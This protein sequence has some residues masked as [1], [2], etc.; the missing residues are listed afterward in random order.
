MGVKTVIGREKIAKAH[1]GEITLPKIKF[2]AIGEGGINLVNGQPKNLSGAETSLFREVLRKEAVLTRVNSTQLNFKVT[3][4][5]ADNL[6][7]K[8]ISEAALFDEAGDMIAIKTFTEKPLDAQ[9][10]IDFTF[11]TQY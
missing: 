7:G 5:G 11:V 4:S 1:A 9:T 10:E 8:K 2:L 6:A 3:I